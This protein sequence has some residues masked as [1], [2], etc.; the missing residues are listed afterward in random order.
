MKNMV[1]ITIEVPD[2]L[3]K[4]FGSEENLKRHLE[5]LITEG[6]EKV[7]GLKWKEVLELINKYG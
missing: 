7:L 2:G 3:I 4:F 1:K 5:G 6:L